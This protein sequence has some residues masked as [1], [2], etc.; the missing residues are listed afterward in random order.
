M[1]TQN[2]HTQKGPNKQRPTEKKRTLSDKTEPDSVTFY[3]IQP[4][5]EVG[6]F[7]QPRNPHGAYK[8]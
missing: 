3:D 8:H 1:Q 2:N 4:G 5:N 7:L 6:L